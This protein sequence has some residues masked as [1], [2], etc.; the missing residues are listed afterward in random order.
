VLELPFMT[1]SPEEHRKAAERLRSFT[2]ITMSKKGLRLLTVHAWPSTQ[3]LSTGPI[4]TLADWKGK[5][6]RVYGPESADF[7]R[8]DAEPMKFFEVAK[9]VNYWHLTGASL[10][11]LAVN[12]K[13]WESLPADLQRVVLTSLRELRFE[14]RQWEDTKA[15]EN[16]AR[17]R[18]QELGMTV[19]EVSPAEITRARTQ[20]KPAWDAWLR[21]TGEEGERAMEFALKALGRA[22]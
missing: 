2:S 18:A 21:R 11:W 3:L 1:G 19:V 22:Q 17:K 4:R 5:K 16:K 12:Q 20:A 8:A 15:W 6:V 10:E 9:F 13:A 7:V 14:D